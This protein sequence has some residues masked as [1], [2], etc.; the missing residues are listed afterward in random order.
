MVLIRV[1]LTAYISIL[2]D[3]FENSCIEFDE[4]TSFSKESDH[5]IIKD[6]HK[7]P[8]EL[9]QKIFC[10]KASISE[11][12]TKYLLASHLSTILSVSESFL[13]ENNSILELNKI[14]KTLDSTV[15]ISKNQLELQ[16]QHIVTS[17]SKELTHDDTKTKAV[18][19]LDLE[20]WLDKV[21]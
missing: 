15:K 18:E 21:L 14:E 13:H 11:A 12:S 20:D 6:N 4:I 16:K 5:N 9:Y 1:T 2:L 8:K 19:K 7:Y 17:N 10:H 3:Q